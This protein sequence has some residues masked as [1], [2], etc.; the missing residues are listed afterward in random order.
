MI[1]RKSGNRGLLKRMTLLALSL[2]VVWQTACATKTN[3][4]VTKLTLGEAEELVSTIESDFPIEV[5]ETVLKWLNY[6]LGDPKGR[7]YVLKTRANMVQYETFIRERLNAKEFPIELLAVPF[8]E[9][10]YVN[11]SLSIMGARGLW[12]FMPATA[13]RF[14][15]KVSVKKDERLDVSKSTEAAIKYY[16]HLLSIKAFEKD[17]RLALLAYN[18]GEGKLSRAIKKVGSNNPWL[19]NDLGDKDYLAKIMAGIILVKN[20]RKVFSFNPLFNS[21]RT[22]KFGFRK[23]KSGKKVYHTGIDLGGG[24]GKNIRS[25]LDGVVAE[26]TDNYRGAPRFGKVIVLNHGDSIETRY[27]HLHDF[28]VSR[29]DRIAAGQTIGTVGSTGVSTG[30]HLHYEVLINGKHV[31]P[32]I[33]F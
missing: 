13:K 5:N 4:G 29:G 16:Q 32:E 21:R 15:L 7:A 23:S 9:S 14:G 8:M 31:D 2:T 20:P 33:F 22:L 28:N 1:T 18:T 27:Y 24:L 25:P 3:F 11:D 10:G 30:P 19:F 6:Y 26:A 12:Q 17:W